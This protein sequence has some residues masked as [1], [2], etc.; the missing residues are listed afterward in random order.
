MFPHKETEMKKLVSVIIAIVAISSVY[1]NE[2]EFAPSYDKETHY[3]QNFADWGDYECWCWKNGIEP[4]YEEFEKSIVVDGHCDFDTMER[5]GIDLENE[6][7]KLFE[8]N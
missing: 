1:A 2:T 5:L 4:N 7:Q 6:T 3:I 8:T